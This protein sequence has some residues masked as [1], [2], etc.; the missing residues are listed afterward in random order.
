MG[1]EGDSPDSP[2]PAQTTLRQCF[3][4]YGYVSL[5]TLRKKVP[6]R[7]RGGHMTLAHVHVEA[8]LSG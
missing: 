7:P 8:P 5:L 3:S 1:H 4:E 2:R 6:V